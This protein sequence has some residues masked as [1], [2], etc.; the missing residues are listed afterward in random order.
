MEADV[1][2]EGVAL[3][4][5]ELIA[6]VF[7][8]CSR[9][10]ELVERVEDET[11]MGLLGRTER[12]LHAEMELG[13]DHVTV[14]GTEPASAPAC[15][16]RRLRHLLQPERLTVEAASVILPVARDGDLNVVEPHRRPLFILTSRQ[17]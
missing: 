4:P 7:D 15:E 2:L 8:A 10:L 13:G 11:R 12:L 1:P 16:R 17:L 3:R 14:E 5:G 9:R 6:G